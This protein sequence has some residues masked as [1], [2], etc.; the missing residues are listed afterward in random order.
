MLFDVVN[1]DAWPGDKV[2]VASSGNPGGG[3]GAETGSMKK[4]EVITELS[5]W[6]I[7]RGSSIELGWGLDNG[8]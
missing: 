3:S 7:V 6:F 4:G 2:V 8:R 1:G 5:D